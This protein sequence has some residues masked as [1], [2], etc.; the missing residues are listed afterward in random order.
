M[1]NKTLQ[2]RRQ[3]RFT[4][5]GLVA[6]YEGMESEYLIALY[7]RLASQRAYSLLKLRTKQ[8]DEMVRWLEQ[9]VE[10]AQRKLLT[11]QQILNSRR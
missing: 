10:L 9:N 6:F 11:I 8:G 5:P 2:A 3:Y 4:Y 7:H 1:S